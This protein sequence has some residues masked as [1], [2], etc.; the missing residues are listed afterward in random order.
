MFRKHIVQMVQ[1]LTK[2]GAKQDSKTSVSQFL[3][4]RV[5]LLFCF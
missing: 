1:I 2:G 3:Q 4:C 5:A